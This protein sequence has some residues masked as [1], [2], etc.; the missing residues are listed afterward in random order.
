MN[1]KLLVAVLTRDEEANIGACLDS[2]LPLRCSMLVVDSG[3]TD[4][5]VSIAE[6]KGAEVVFH[7]FESIA[8]QRNWV[9][10]NY[11]A[12]YD[13]IL[14]LDADERISEKLAEELESLS[15][16][17]PEGPFGYYIPRHF[18]F[19][20]KRLRYGRFK[21]NR[22]LRLLDPSRSSIA[23][24]TR[25]LEYAKVWGPVAS[26]KSPMIHENR[27]PLSEWIKK[28]DWYSTRQAEDEAAGMGR[29]RV[30][31]SENPDASRANSLLAKFVPPLARP[32]LTFADSYFFRLGF[33][34]G[35]EGFIYAFLHDFWYPLLIA[36]KLDEIR[37]GQRPS[38]LSGG[39]GY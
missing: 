11:G 3:S 24:Q 9:I 19:M 38:T 20:G 2:A 22:V 28:H 12:G 7:E 25:T 18:Y 32:F 8:R 23:E 30:D 6:K 1:S 21:R 10:D 37:S 27:K 13:W 16:P 14:F 26:L 31:A 33:L 35:K 39:G 5:T 36:A 34:D 4:R 15:P 17:R 29:Q